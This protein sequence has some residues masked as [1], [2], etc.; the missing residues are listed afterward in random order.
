M[1]YTIHIDINNHVK[2]LRNI[3]VDVLSV[4]TGRKIRHA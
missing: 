2:V 4:E 3:S 1:Y